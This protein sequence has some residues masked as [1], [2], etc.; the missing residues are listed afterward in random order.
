MIFTDIKVWCADAMPE[1]A[2][3]PGLSERAEG[4]DGGPYQASRA[5]KC[6]FCGKRIVFSNE[7]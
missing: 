7:M 1:I 6:T 2:V 4:E 3:V 5:S